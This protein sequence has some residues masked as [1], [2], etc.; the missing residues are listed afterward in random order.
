MNNFID[1]YKILNVSN[2]ATFEEIKEAYRASV[3]ETHPDSKNGNTDSFKL[4]KEAYEV[5]SN[6]EKRRRYNE[7]LFNYTK[8]NT[9]VSNIKMESVPSKT[10]SNN[11]KNSKQN[12]NL[13][14]KLSLA[15]NVVL[16]GLVFWGYNQLI[17]QRQH[18]NLV[19]EKREKSVNSL[20]KLNEEYKLLDD[21]YASLETEYNNFVEQTNAEQSNAKNKYVE[22]GSLEALDPGVTVI[23]KSEVEYINPEGAFTQGSSKEHV[24]LIMGTPSSLSSH[25]FGGETWWYG[26][27]AYVEFNKEGV[28]EGWTDINGDTLKVQ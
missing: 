23:A 16:I 21:K 25:P 18:T 26:G 22:E 9:P 19:Q 4:V 20:L 15:L 28:V 5:L 3:K 2:Y 10:N 27:S 8:V 17:D 6:E 12:L 1:Y 11:V 7:F 13:F 24:K 14:T